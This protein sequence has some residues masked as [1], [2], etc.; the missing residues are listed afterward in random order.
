VKQHLD[1]WLEDPAVTINHRRESSAVPGELWDAT[2][3]LTLGDTRMLGRLVRWRI[4]GTPSGITYD[5]LF[6]SPPFTVLHEEK[7]GLVCGL[8]GRIWS[9]S[10][11][12]PVVAGPEEFRQWSAPGTVRVLFGNWVEPGEDGL[13]VLVSETRIAV[14]D[15][16]ARA[17]LSV[18]RPLITGFHSLIASEAMSVAIRRA[19]E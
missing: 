16:E 19:E 3:S 12:Y 17:G 13:S 18:V 4:P 2:R 6:R 8:V 5:E 10:R 9:L 14:T 1:D 15:R 11:D 7:D